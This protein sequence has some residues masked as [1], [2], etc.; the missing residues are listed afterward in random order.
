MSGICGIIRFDGDPGALTDIAC[1]TEAMAYRGPDGRAQW[2]DEAAALGHC[3]LRTTV[4]ADEEAQP[5]ESACGRFVL[6]CD[7]TLWNAPDLRAEVLRAGVRP[8][9]GS[10]SALVLAAFEAFGRAMLARIDGDFAFAVWDR[11]RR[12]LFCARDRIGMRPFHYHASPSAGFV[13]A[14]DAEAVLAVRA[15]PRR[16]NEARIADGIVTGLEGYDLVST[17]WQ[18]IARL[19]PAHCLTVTSTGVTTERYWTFEPPKVLKLGSDAAYERAYREVMTEAVR[20][21]L[22]GRATGSMLSGGVDSATI[23]ALARRI[24]A[25][26]GTGPHATFS[27]IGPD[28]A[29]CRETWAI[30]QSAGMGGIDPHFVDHSALGDLTPEL[31]DLTLCPP[32]LFEGHMALIRSVYL[33]AH[34][35]GFRAVLDGAAGDSVLNNGAALVYFLRRGRIL[36]GVRMARGPEGVRGMGPVSVQLAQAMRRAITP[37]WF[38]RLRQPWTVRRANGADRIA[39]SLIRADFAARVSLPDRFIAQERGRQRPFR[40]GSPA[41]RANGILRNNV[42]V[43][44][45]RYEREASRVGIEARDPNHDLSVLSFCVS[46][47]VDQ[48][49]RNGWQ[50]SILRRAMGGDLPASVLWRPERT[51]L[52]RYFTSAV[53]Q[54][55]GPSGSLFSDQDFEAIAPYIDVDRLRAEL[56]VCESGDGLPPPRLKAIFL[57]LFLARWLAAHQ[58]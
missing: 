39:E 49:T 10:D 20:R 32:S 47:P 44:R 57:A 29:T 58:G 36:A 38:R 14:S 37:D 51:E 27:A 33:T 12:E 11:S 45:E 8:R 54:A 30:H 13:F 21:R 17:F 43:A 2:Q 15:V 4:E 22:R 9:N 42:T 6:T 50:K 53:M 40:P 26:D 7:A 52:G 55:A 18:E 41:Q 34:R 5:L 19:P 46:L 35:A 24:R 31:V 3:L 28:P 25:A 23:S 48:I 16:L 1:M 56:A